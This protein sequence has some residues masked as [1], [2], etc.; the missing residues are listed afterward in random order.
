MGVLDFGMPDF[1]DSIVLYANE[2]E[3]GEK[4]SYFINIIQLR[5]RNFLYWFGC[6]ENFTTIIRTSALE[7]TRRRRKQIMLLHFLRLKIGRDQVLKIFIYLSGFLCFNFTVLSLLSY[8]KLNLFQDIDAEQ[9]MM[10]NRLGHFMIALIR[11]DILLML[12]M[13]LHN[14]VTQVIG[15]NL[16]HGYNVYVAQF[17]KTFS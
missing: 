11:S 15:K 13:P 10:K 12:L 7:L 17:H 9:I 4:K 2:E 3:N 5:H 1:A 8:W 6:L 16:N 14:I